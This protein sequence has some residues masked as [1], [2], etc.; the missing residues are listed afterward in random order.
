[1][2]SGTFTR[3]RRHGALM[4]TSAAAWGLT[5]VAFGLAPYLWAALV[6]LALGGAVN[7]VLS[8][9]RNAI[10]QAA[11]DDALR[12]RVQGSLT[13]VLI[14]GPQTATVLHEFAGW[15]V[16]PRTA[17]CIGGLLTTITVALIAR[18]TPALWHYQPAESPDGS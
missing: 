2:L 7:F 17:I 10:T 6:A 14:G 9:F 3:A 1:M 16:G 18:T 11:S 13:I 5:V 12:G 8:T 15:A 4:A